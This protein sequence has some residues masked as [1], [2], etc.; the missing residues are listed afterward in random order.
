MDM[1][2]YIFTCKCSDS[3]VLTNEN[4]GKTKVIDED[5]FSKETLSEE[6]SDIFFETN[7][8][9]LSCFLNIFT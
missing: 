4:V 1:E 2:K 6:I 5:S 9:V 7:F 8:E 3:I